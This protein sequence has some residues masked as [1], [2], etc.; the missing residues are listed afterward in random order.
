MNRK[1]DPCHGCDCLS[2]YGYCTMPFSDRWYACPIESEKPENK[3][4]LMLYAEW[5]AERRKEG[6]E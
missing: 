3:A 2:E 6:K 1:T 4:A 5:V